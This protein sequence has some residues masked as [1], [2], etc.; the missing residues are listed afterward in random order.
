MLRRHEDAEEVTLDT[1]TRAWRNASTYD[2]SRGS[3]IAWLV[4]MARSLAIDR[5]APGANEPA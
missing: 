1:Y 4:M 5:I 3:V 2:P